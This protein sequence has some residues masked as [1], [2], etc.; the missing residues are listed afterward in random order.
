[1]LAHETFDGPIW[2]PACGDGAIARVLER[3]GHRVIATDLIDR[4]YGEAGV[5]FLT[6]AEPRA[7]HIVTNPPYG[8]R[9]C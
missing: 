8:A 7:R 6:T 4:G 1:M 5:D 3:A 9:T 2:E